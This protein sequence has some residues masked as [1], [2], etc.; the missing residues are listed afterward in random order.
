MEEPTVQPLQQLLMD[1]KGTHLLSKTNRGLRQGWSVI[2]SLGSKASRLL[3]LATWGMLLEPK[4]RFGA[5]QGVYK[6]R[7]P[8]Q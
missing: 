7:C 6:C 1:S 2:G 3:L 5:S 8:N 4:R